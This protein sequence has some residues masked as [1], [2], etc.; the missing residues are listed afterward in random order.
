MRR[1]I[2]FLAG[3]F[4][5]CMVWPMKII[6]RT[7]VVIFNSRA[8]VAALLLFCALGSAR[9]DDL[10]DYLRAQMRQLHI[11]GL[12]VAVVRDGRIAR[13]RGYGLADVELN[14]P[15]TED[16]VFEIGSISKQFTGVAIMMLVE[17]GKVGLDD[18]ITSYLAGVPEAW[19]TVTV[20]QLLT[21]SSGIQEY[22]SVPG[23]FSDT[24]RPGISH[25]DIA[26]MFFERLPLEFRPG[27]TWAYSNSGYLLLGNIVEKA[28]GKSYWEFLDERIFKPLAMNATRSSEPTAII[29]NRASGYEWHN[30]KLENRV[31]LT[32]NAY[33]AGSIVST[34][35]DMAKWD[36]ALYTENLLKKSSLDQ[37]WTVYKA[38]GG[39]TAPVNY[40]F[41]WELNTYHGHR[42]IS[43]SG[44][45]P[46]FSSVIYRFV[47]DRLTV[48]VLTNH[49]DRVIDHLAIDVAGIYIPA[50]AR[51]KGASID[52]DAKTSQELKTA[53]LDL[54]EGKPDPALFTP[55]MQLFLRTS[56]GK[57]L[58]QWLAAD[59]KI[60]SF[61]FSEREGTNDERILRYKA[62]LG[63]ATRWFTFTVTAD[64]RI[65]QIF[66]W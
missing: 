1:V 41:G 56:I 60:K 22:L 17:E 18:K 59:G 12:S 53:L 44:G 42:V 25:D 46:G 38:G 15:A 65:A 55:A 54:F 8:I 47:D 20:R 36:A 7:K 5:V 50:L 31:A 37:M 39:A 51:P 43:H 57:E 19:S 33:A 21:H 58:W 13:A 66:W 30:N 6:R 4:A 28:S 11:P 24:A 9:A 45:T 14:S 48:I 16:T 32:E 40:G 3:L 52:P 23:L 2:R 35:R 26:K 61:N 64:G 62:V 29:P 63:N 49:A 34:V 27:E 10:D